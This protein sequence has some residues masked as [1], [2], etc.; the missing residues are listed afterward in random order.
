MG[1]TV[2][3]YCGG[4]K[5]NGKPGCE[6]LN[7]DKPGSKGFSGKDVLSGLAW[8]GTL[9]GL[10][11]I[12]AHEVQIEADATDAGPA[13]DIDAFQAV[14]HCIDA[15]QLADLLGEQDE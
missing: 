2:G 6:L 11:S 10:P 9:A 15:H 14:Q 12:A 13:P 4:C 8:I 5:D 1:E 7:I 3:N